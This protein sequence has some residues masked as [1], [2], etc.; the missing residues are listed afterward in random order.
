MLQPASHAQ[1]A[2][3]HSAPETDTEHSEHKDLDQ[4][5]TKSGAASHAQVDRICQRALKVNQF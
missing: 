1:P 3:A 5:P 2:P 4:F